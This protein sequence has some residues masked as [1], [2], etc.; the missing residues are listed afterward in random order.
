VAGQGGAGGRKAGVGAED[1]FIGLGA[2]LGDS[3]ATLA[4]AAERLMSLPQMRRVV[5]SSPW[6]T[7]PVGK[8]D[9]P[10]FYN[11]VARGQYAGGPQ[12]LLAGLL[13]IEDERGR[14]RQERWGPRT[15]D[16]DLLLFGGRMLDEPELTVPHPRMHERVFVLAPL[17]E[18]APDLLLPGLR[19]TPAQLMAAMGPHER[20]T[21]EAQRAAWPLSARL[22]SA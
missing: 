7:A 22:G 18:L 6:R 14:V 3:L 16:L 13:A 2:N 12:E 11:A 8:M 17:M 4:W 15:L 5:V 9:Q 20:H 19:R 21:Q 1:V 10:D